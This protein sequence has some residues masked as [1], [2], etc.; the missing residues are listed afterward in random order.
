MISFR[1]GKNIV[2]VKQL[3]AAMIRIF[4]DANFKLQKW[5][6]NIKLEKN[7]GDNAKLKLGVRQNGTKVFGVS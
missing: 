3:K 4:G 2:E 1:L 5:P 7:D 6:S